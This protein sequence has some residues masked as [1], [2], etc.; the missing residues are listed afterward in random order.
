MYLEDLKK[1][2]YEFIKGKVCIERKLTLIN[3]EHF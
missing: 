2:F 1:D 3:L